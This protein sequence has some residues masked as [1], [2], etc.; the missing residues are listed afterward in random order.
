[1]ILMEWRKRSHQHA[2]EDLRMG[3]P[4]RW[5]VYVGIVLLI[6]FVGEHSEQSFIYFQF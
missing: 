5:A 2:L 4:G 6:V 3:R 1:M